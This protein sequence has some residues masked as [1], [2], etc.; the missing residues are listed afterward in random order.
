MASSNTTQHIVPIADI[1]DDVVVLKN[2]QICMLLLASSI[3]FALKSSDE[4]QA[5][6]SQFQAFLNSLEFSIQI[7]AQSRR[8]DIRPYLEILRAREADQTNDLMRTQLR[9]Y[10][11]FISS[12]TS[13]VDIMS[14]NFFV[15]I[16][17]SPAAFELKGL[18]RLLGPLKGAGQK[19]TD[20]DKFFEDRT[21]LEQRV[22]IV[23]QGLA[24]IGVRTTPLGT[25]ELIELFYHI[26]NPEDLS[27]APRR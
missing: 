18:G 23:E 10:I 8:L 25:E 1:H 6:L 27:S 14:K 17:Y 5:I 15:V 3:N 22:S 4:Q 19:R 7:Y 26:F 24:R 12:F 13:Q 16:P 9:E 2:G 20:Q 11:E 21:Q